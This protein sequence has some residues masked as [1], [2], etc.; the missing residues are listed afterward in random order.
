MNSLK[1]S[2]AHACADKFLAY[3]HTKNGWISQNQQSRVQSEAQK[4]LK[5]KKKRENF[6]SQ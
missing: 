3:M 5:S 6:E 1:I 4:N 2:C